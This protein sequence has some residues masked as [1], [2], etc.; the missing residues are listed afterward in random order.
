MTL[1]ERLT[2]GVRWLEDD[3]RHEAPRAG[4][5][6]R[7]GAGEAPRA[8]AATSAKCLKDFVASGQ[9]PLITYVRT[10]IENH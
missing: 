6:E 2:A 5:R 1:L 8:S 10:C 3:G 9:R 4:A 7:C